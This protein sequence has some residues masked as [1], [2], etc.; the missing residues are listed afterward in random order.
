MYIYIFKLRIYV[1]NINSNKTTHR[2]KYMSVIF[3]EGMTYLAAGTFVVPF[4]SIY[5]THHI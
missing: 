4:N 5:H 1:F 3:Y 2:E